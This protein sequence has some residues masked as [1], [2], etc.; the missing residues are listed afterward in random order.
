MKG[1]LAAFFLIAGLLFV[2]LPMMIGEPH[3][4]RSL[5]MVLVQFLG[6]IFWV[7]GNCCLAAK[8]DLHPAW[9]LVSLFFVLFTGMFFVL[10][11][12]V[13]FWLARYCSKYANVRRAAFQNRGS[14]SSARYVDPD[15]PW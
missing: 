8:I 9:G 4:N 1:L 15:S 10:S 7:V 12:G 2:F 11:P 3:L 6:M 5:S 14:Q 13:L